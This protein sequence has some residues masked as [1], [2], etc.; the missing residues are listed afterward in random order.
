MSNTERKGDWQQT[1]SGKQFWPMDPRVEDICIEDIAHALSLQCRFAGHCRKFYSV[2]EHSVRVSWYVESRTETLYGTKLAG[3]LH[4]ATE[5]Y[6]VDVPRPM[7][8]HLIGYKEIE[9]GLARVIE[10]WACLVAGALDAPTIKR[11][12]EVLLMTEARDLLG[13]SPAPWTWARGVSAE[14]LP[15]VIHPWSSSYAERNF[16]D[17]FNKL[18]G[19]M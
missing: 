14:P 19:R 5:A 18:K 2:A 15:D 6:C 17:R 9:A 4:D 16:I 8:P 10:Q 11:A 7:K 13:P 1:F 12:D 3:L